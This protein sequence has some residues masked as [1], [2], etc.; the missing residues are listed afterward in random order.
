[1]AVTHGTV[2][3][4]LLSAISV[5]AAIV[6]LG[7]CSHA[8]SDEPAST[9]LG[10]GTSM[11][12]VELRTPDL[13][14]LG[15][16]Y[17]KG[18]GLEVLEEDDHTLTLGIDGAPLIELV[19][20]DAPADDIA[21]AGLYHSAFLFPDEETLVDALV[22]MVAV[23]PES[24]QGSSDHNVSQAFYFGDPDGN[25]VE[26]Y[27]DR[28][29]DD[30]EWDGGQ[31]TMGS[32]PLDPNAFLDEHFVDIADREDSA[33][34]V[35]MGHVH[36]RGGNVADAEEFYAETLGFKVT[37][38]SDGAVFFAAGDYH[39]HMAVNVWSSEGAG[40][41]PETAGLGHVTIH[42][43]DEGELDALEARLKHVKRNYTREGAELHTSDPW[44][45]EVIVAVKN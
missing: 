42:V 8:S 32:L 20:T 31:V 41:R 23:A 40:E 35:V 13:E 7:G 11:G 3:T 24:F 4:R 29:R 45:T 18:V 9:E 21:E 37:A 15:R 2:R 12:A 33:S 27:V 36:L 43:G 5:L 17:V 44:G 39:H 34:G 26:L 6:I 25:G 16:F 30:W 22:R 19:E 1:M 28:P 38:R 14:S 10:D